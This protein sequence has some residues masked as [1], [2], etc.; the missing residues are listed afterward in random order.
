MMNKLAF[1]IIILSAIGSITL[2]G[3]TV[4]KKAVTAP[5]VEAPKI[6]APKVVEDLGN[7]VPFTRD[8]FFKLRENGLDIKKLKFYVDNTIALNKIASSG[9]LEI[10]E[11]GTLVNKKG[12]ADNVIKITPQVAGI[13]EYVEA[14]GL[15]LNFG[16]PNS[17]LKFINNTQSP[18]FFSFAGDKFD[19]M[20]GTVELPYNNST[21]KANCEGCSNV[22]EVKLLIKQLD[23][24]A[25]MG[26]GTIEPGV[27]GSRSSLN[28][29]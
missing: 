1:K 22:T 28:G 29:Y 18:K 12:V 3:C 25:G 11:L 2:L 20:N 10:N 6:Q 15:R 23:I 27:G 7:L 14:D 21:Y 13:V 8:L 24:E 4:K 16:R 19:K 5:V 9:N 26:K 17:T